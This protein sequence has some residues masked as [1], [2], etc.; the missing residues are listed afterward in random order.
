MLISFFPLSCNELCVSCFFFFSQWLERGKETKC[1]KRGA[2]VLCVF[3]LH[4]GG[5]MEGQRGDR[6]E[7]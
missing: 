5:S 1:T 6:G 4:V 7:K 2:V 3:F